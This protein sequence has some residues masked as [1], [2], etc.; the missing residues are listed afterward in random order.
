MYT[1]LK[2]KVT[3]LIHGTYASKYLLGHS[4]HA[5]KRSVPK[6]IL[7]SVN[8]TGLRSTLSYPIVRLVKEHPKCTILN[9]LPVSRPNSSKIFY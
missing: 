5:R 2:S 4:Q 9:V 1:C 8:S 6:D 7:H 3:P